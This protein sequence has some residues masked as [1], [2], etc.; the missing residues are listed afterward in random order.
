ML[1]LVYLQQSKFPKK[2]LFKEALLQNLYGYHTACV[3]KLYFLVFFFKFTVSV[4]VSNK[5]FRSLILCYVTF[6]ARF[7]INP[8]KFQKLNVDKRVHFMHF[9]LRTN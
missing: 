9:V 4:N 7:N 2:D 8:F 6:S 3:Q 5:S 1:Y